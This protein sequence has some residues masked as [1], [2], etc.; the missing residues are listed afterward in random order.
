MKKKNK[1]V[2]EMVLYVAKCRYCSK[3]IFTDHSFVSFYSKDHAHYQCMKDD[4][5][6]QQQDPR[7]NQY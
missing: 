5:I 6:K 3:D 7:H 2:Q 4:Y 1:K